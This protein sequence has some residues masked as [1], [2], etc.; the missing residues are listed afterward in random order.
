MIKRI[1]VRRGNVPEINLFT[2]HLSLRKLYQQHRRNEY[3]KIIII[4]IWTFLLM[5]T[6]S[7]A[8]VALRSF[9]TINNAA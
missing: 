6:A 3:K 9:D 5:R 2:L 8:T 4:I 7:A 1:S